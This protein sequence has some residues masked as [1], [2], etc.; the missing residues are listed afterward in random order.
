MSSQ[1]A[2]PNRDGTTTIRSLGVVQL[3]SKKT[4]HA[5]NIFKKICNYYDQLANQYV[6]KG[7]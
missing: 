5:A 6:F 4:D 1:I 2:T 3:R 7:T